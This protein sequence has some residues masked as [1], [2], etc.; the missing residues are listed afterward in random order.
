MSAVVV[1][2]DQQWSVEATGVTMAD[3]LELINPQTMTCTLLLNGEVVQT[4]KVERCDNC[5]MITK[6]DDFGYQKG[7]A[8]EK[9]LWFCGGCR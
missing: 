2:H 9:I 8:G 5:A 7:Q 3:F 1:R 4:Y 6:L